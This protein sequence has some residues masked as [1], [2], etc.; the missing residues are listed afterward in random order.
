M[1]LPLSDNQEETSCFSKKSGVESVFVDRKIKTAG[2]KLPESGSYFFIEGLTYRL[3]MPG[4]ALFRLSMKRF[5]AHSFSCTG[6]V[7]LYVEN[8][9]LEGIDDAH[10]ADHGFPADFRKK[11]VVVTVQ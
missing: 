1:R 5:L 4:P 2:V 11:L 3:L 6:L 9:V 10:A 7:L 8:V